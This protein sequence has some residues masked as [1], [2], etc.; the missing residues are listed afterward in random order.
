[1]RNLLTLFIILFLMAGYSVSV[2]ASSPDAA[3][4]FK[5]VGNKSANKG[6]VAKKVSETKE[7]ESKYAGNSDKRAD[8]TEIKSKSEQF[9]YHG[10]NDLLLD[11]KGTFLYI[12]EKDARRLTR[13]TLKENDAGFK[14]EKGDLVWVDLPLIPERMTWFADQR[15]I[16]IAGGEV[17]GGVMIVRLLD[18][19]APK[20]EDPCPMI[21]EKTLPAGHTPSDVATEL[22]KDGGTTIYVSNRFSDTISVLDFETGKTLKTWPIGREPYAIK[23]VPKF[24]KLVV[25]NLLP[26]MDSDNGYTSS[27]VRVVD[28]KTEKV[29]KIELINGVSN[30][31]DIA[32]TPDGRYAFVSGT[33]GNFQTVTTQVVGGWIMENVLSVIDVELAE[34]VD[35]FF[36]DDATLGAPTPWGVACDQEG[37]FLAVSPAGTDEILF[38]PMDRILK[39]IKSRPHWNRPG[40]GAYT[41]TYHG[42][43]EIE[44]PLRVRVKMGQKGMRRLVIDSGTVYCTAYFEDA[45]AVLKV[46]RKPPYKNHSD[47]FVRAEP[48]PKPVHPEQDVEP[49]ANKAVFVELEP[50]FPLKGVEVER[51]LIRIGSKPDLA[52]D[53]VRRGEMLFHD[54]TFCMEN[55]MACSSCHPEGRVD[56]LNWDLVNDGLGNPKNTKNMLYAHETPPSMISGVR[57]D[58]ETAVRAGVEH[59]LY[60][61][62][63]E[64]EAAAIDEYLK[65]LKPVPSPK[66]VDGKLN[67]SALRGKFLFES[68]RTKCSVCHIPPY[69]TDLR[70]HKVKSYAPFETVQKFDTPTLIELWRTAP[71]LNTGHFTSLKEVLLKGKHGNEDGLLDQLTDQEIDDLI[72]YILSL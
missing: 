12:L 24:S 23:F 36:L 19:T 64:I 32:I 52:Q 21:L 6:I 46:N 34:A 9:R 27:S 43:G 45:V 62:L 13:L 29:K 15:R 30:L 35:A 22:R 65:S 61:S 71:Y 70:S 58:A 49:D 26:E 57:K 47:S 38:M 28:V 51:S 60:S 2:L 25:A 20:K 53:D 4:S 44:F 55:W 1:M 18:S 17:K 69:F 72:E 59:I 31:R 40:E 7:K 5:A 33:Q 11:Q 39:L 67:P 14:S 37:K 63:P 16:A 68:D 50:F 8:H 3:E 56:G 66:L 42:D 41:Y 48:V 10:P 54:A